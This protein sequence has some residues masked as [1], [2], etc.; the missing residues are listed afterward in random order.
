MQ[1]LAVN[2]ALSQLLR[3]QAGGKLRRLR[4]GFSSRRRM[5]LTALAIVMAVVWLG[6]AVATVLLREAFDPQSLGR[7]TSLLL[8]LYFVWHIVRVAYK[9][10][11]EA[12]EWSPAEREF[13]CGGPF[14]RR[15]LLAYRLALVLTATVPKALVAA[16]LLTP[17]LPMWGSGF[18]GILLGLVL[19]EYVRVGL[20]IWACGVS[21]RVYT[22]GRVAVLGGL[23]ALASV[24]FWR[25]IAAYQ[26]NLVPGRTVWLDL[27]A[28]WGAALDSFRETWFGELL[29]LPFATMVG[30]MMA[31]EIGPPL[32]RDLGLSAAF[33]LV[34]GY[35]AVRLDEFFEAKAVA[36]ERGAYGR[37]R[38]AACSSE[39]MQGGS[40]RLPRV[41]RLGGAGPL[42][43]RQLKGVRR[44]GVS[45]AIAL[46]IPGLMA[47]LPLTAP[48]HPVTTFLSVV[49]SALFYS[50]LLLPAALKFDFRSDFDRLPMLKMHPASLP[51][52]VIG[53]IAAPILLMTVY[54]IAVMLVAAIARPVPPGIIGLSL[55]LVLPVNVFFVALDN[56]IFLLYPHRQSQEGLEVFLRSTLTFTGK[57]LIFAFG[58]VLISA[59]AFG[60]HRI[61]IATG[62]VNRFQLLFIP[63]ALAMAAASAGLVLVLL[64]RAFEQYDPS[65]EGGA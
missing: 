51:A 64:I 21:K 17:D 52:L 10:P 12:I 40:G 61:A 27:F 53:Q 49:G 34:A 24:G 42:C 13:L 54:Q 2:P 58:Y 32:L 50:F 19:L 59:W 37:A 47:C 7:S 41:P 45:V 15:E 43:W 29:E 5:L 63:G 26:A 22:A 9:R 31:P 4:R 1:S 11:D 57:T 55:L 23:A 25:A 38:A 28:W 60:A 36:S 48:G 56:L 8:L 33:V 39:L 6:N 35:A 14:T 18:V 30:V 65:A 3:V 20:E 16:L 46:L 44:H 62:D